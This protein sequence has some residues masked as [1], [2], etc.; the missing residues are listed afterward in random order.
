[1]KKTLISAL[2]GLA[3]VSLALAAEPAA[4]KVDVSPNPLKANQAGDLVLEVVDADWNT[5]TDFE[6]DVIYYVQDSNGQQVTDVTLPNAEDDV[7]RYTF[8]I[9]DQGKKVFRWGIS[10]PNP[11][12]YIVYAESLDNNEIAGEE[13]VKIV[14]ENTLAG[15]ISISS[16]T[17]WEIIS[18]P[19]VDVVGET[20]LPNSLVQIYIDGEPVITTRSDE[21][22]KFSVA[23]SDLKKGN[24][25]VRAAIKSL[26]WNEIIAQSEEILFVYDFDDNLLKSIT[27]L[28]SNVVKI[29]EKIQVDVETRDE[30]NSA[31]L[32]IGEKAAPMA[33][34]DIGKFSSIVV[35]K[36]AGTY[37]VSLTL[38]TDNFSKTY[39]WVDQIIVEKIQ[40]H[41]LAWEKYTITN[42]KIQPVSSDSVIISWDY[43]WDI[44]AFVV[45]YGSGENELNYGI[46]VTNPE[47]QISGLDI[48]QKYYFKILGVSIT[49]EEMSLHP[50]YGAPKSITGHYMD[51]LEVLAES[52]QV[53]AYAPL[54]GEWCKV[55]NIKIESVVEKGKHYLRWDPVPGAQ[56]YIVYRSDT[57]VET[58]D[59]M[60]IYMVTTGTKVVYDYNPDAEKD[61]YNWFAVEAD[62]DT[63]R[64]QIW[65]IEKVKVGPF[66]IFVRLFI[67]GLIAYFAYKIWILYREV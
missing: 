53:L 29:G 31:I 8:T 58:I 15:T 66:D 2:L 54:Q 26:D 35:L 61:I 9:E 67:L 45:Q 34:E 28:P 52:P 12:T 36:E 60:E 27:F 24:H 23:V 1:M 20:D 16:P 47:V 42:V 4:I 37:P 38:E 56:R 49:P 22:G 10:F 50:L 55:S 41:P 32:K 43:S 33:Q 62:C 13:E 19:S 65:E 21:W 51:T 46:M 18:T 30:V 64:A 39:T 44:P 6:G 5:V 17:S 57:P 48:N 63:S 40:T 59:Q 11:G 7:W 25:T 3:F 14:D